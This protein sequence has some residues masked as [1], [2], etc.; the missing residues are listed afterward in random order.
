MILLDY[1]NEQEVE[2]VYDLD[3]NNDGNV[4]KWPEVSPNKSQ[5][6]ET[7]ITDG[8]M[9]M[10]ANCNHCNSSELEDF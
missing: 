8:L 4:F 6:T 2:W 9:G 7:V 5:G 1:D 3:L 10:R